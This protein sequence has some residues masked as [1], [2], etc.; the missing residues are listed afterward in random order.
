MYLK[1]EEAKIYTRN[2]FEGF[3]KEFKQIIFCWHKK[4]QEVTITVYEVYF[5]LNQCAY[6]HNVEVNHIDM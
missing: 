6:Y 3:M 1:V 5:E 2:V 4:L